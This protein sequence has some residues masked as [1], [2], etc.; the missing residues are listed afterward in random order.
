M[1]IFNFTYEGKTV[2]LDLKYKISLISDLSGTGKTFMA[3]AAKEMNKLGNKHV[4]SLIDAP[5]Y[6]VIEDTVKL[7]IIDENFVATIRRL[8]KF[9]TLL[10][11]PFYFVIITRFPIKD[12]NY[13]Y[14]Q[15]YTLDCCDGVYSLKRKY[16]DYNY[17]VRAPD[18]I[19]DKCSGFKYFKQF[20][21]DIET[22][23]GKNNI[24]NVA[25]RGSNVIAD[26]C[27]IGSEMPR[28]HGHYDLFLY[29]SFE[30]L[31]LRRHNLLPDVSS[32]LNVEQVY[33]K[34][35]TAN[36]PH[37]YSK[38]RFN[39]AYSSREYIADFEIPNST[40]EELLNRYNSSAS[41]EDIREIIYN[42][43]GEHTTDEAIKMAIVL[44]QLNNF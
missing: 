36:L 10:K 44:H 13:S 28:L 9:H 30:W 41:I 23:V 11:E 39:T 16:P 25:D 22:T 3:N 31:L 18:Y 38:S 12:I 14:K 33:T 15:V 43:Q 19:E 32:D 4:L 7:V 20:Y 27:S 37:K 17:L 2:S 6:P 40:I 21:E 5:T 8:R 24:V 26:G 34:H 42:M 35:A 29:E 1:P